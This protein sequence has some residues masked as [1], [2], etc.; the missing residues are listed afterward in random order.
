MHACLCLF[1]CATAASALSIGELR[2]KILS[3]T[4]NEAVFGAF[5]V[6]R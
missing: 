6:F 4:R 2:V 1:F 3:P 5:N